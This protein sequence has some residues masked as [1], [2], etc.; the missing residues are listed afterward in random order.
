MATDKPLTKN[1]EEGRAPFDFK[2]YSAAGGYES[3]RKAIK[4]EPGDIANV[5]TTAAME[6]IASR[7][8]EIDIDPAL[9]NNADMQSL[10]AEI[11]ADLDNEVTWKLEKVLQ[12]AITDTVHQCISVK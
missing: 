8:A 6:S 5:H 11:A 1:I 7:V 9:A 12:S 3:V 2:Q 4:M 10:I